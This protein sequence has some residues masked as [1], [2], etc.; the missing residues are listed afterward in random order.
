VLLLVYTNKLIN[1]NTKYIFVTGGVASSLGK[2]VIAATLGR[3]LQNRGFNITIQKFDP[4]INVDPGT[5][6]PNEHGECYVTIDGYECDLDLGHYER[7]TDIKT[8]RNNS[9]TTGRIYQEV[10][11]KERR[12][13]YGGKTV[14]VVPHITDAIKENMLRTGKENPELD[15]VITEIG[16]TVGDIEGLPFLESI[17][18]LKWEL[19]EDA[20]VVHLAYVPYIA[21]AGELKTKPTQ[22]SVKTL[23]SY[24]IQPDCIVLRSEHPLPQGLRKKVASFCNVQPEYVLHSPDV[25]SIYALPLKMHE[26]KLAIQVLKLSGYQN[27]E[28][29]PV[30]KSHDK[31]HHFVEMWQSTAEELHIG[32]VGKYDLQDAYKSITESLKIAGIYCGRK[33]VT[34]FIDAEE[35]EKGKQLST[36]FAKEKNGSSESNDVKLSGAILC[37]GFGDRGIE[38]KITAARYLRENNIPTLGICLGMQIM[39]IEFARNVLGHKTANSTEFNKQTDC[40]I[41]DMM[42]EQKHIA[43]LGGTMRLGGYECELIANSLSHTI[44]KKDVIVERHRHRYELNSN[45]INEMEAKGMKISGNNPQSKLAEII[46]L[47]SNHFYIGSQFHPEYS[48]TVL[49]PHPLFMAFINSCID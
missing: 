46:E 21:A 12:G 43:N 27:I 49:N 30:T 45:Y 41:I 16:G 39:A 8:T 3:L 31:W 34:H 48:S 35:I 20:L 2:G 9:F 10:I 23:Q 29:L 24:G 47:P 7:F 40:P 38:G 18:Q 6:N 36:L 1:M 22:H 5:L 42:E 26:E 13:D 19:G 14:Q 11:N 4:Y 25:P 17:R 15:F 37:P 28:S 44:Y 33:I 32:F